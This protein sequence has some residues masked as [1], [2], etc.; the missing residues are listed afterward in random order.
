MCASPG[1][2]GLEA[3][4]RYRVL[5]RLQRDF[6]RFRSHFRVRS[7]H[8]RWV[9]LSL[10]TAPSTFLF[11]CSVPGDHDG[12]GPYDGSA[13]YRLRVRAGRVPALNTIGTGIALFAEAQISPLVLTLFVHCGFAEVVPAPTATF[14]IATDANRRHPHVFARYPSTPHPRQEG[15]GEWSASPSL[16]YL[17]PTPQSRL[18]CTQRSRSAKTWSSR[19]RCAVVCNVPENVP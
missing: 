2:R 13:V 8:S 5:D 10:P 7:G 16:R 1:D 19:R 14:T 17:V 4:C 11:S 15:P 3:F 6:L 18:G 9:S 12:G